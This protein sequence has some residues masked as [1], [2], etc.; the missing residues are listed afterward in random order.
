MLRY[1]SWIPIHFAKGAKWMGH[2]TFE[3]WSVYPALTAM[4]I[5]R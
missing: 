5:P 4:R 1:G 3:A 2:P